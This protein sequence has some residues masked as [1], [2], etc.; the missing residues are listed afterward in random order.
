M[1]MLS[2]KKSTDNK[3]AS[4]AGTSKM[5]HQCSYEYDVFISYCHADS[6]HATYIM[7][8]LQ[9]AIPGIKIFL[10]REQLTTGN[11]LRHG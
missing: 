1:L 6:K 5:K 3:A 2:G 9:N 7:K 10:D 4:A 8:A 11:F